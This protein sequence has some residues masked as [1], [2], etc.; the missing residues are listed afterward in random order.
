[1]GGNAVKRENL[2]KLNRLIGRI[3]SFEIVMDLKDRGW[4]A[5]CIEQ[6]EEIYDDEG[7][8]MAAIGFGPSSAEDRV[9]TAIRNAPNQELNAKACKEA[10]GNGTA[11]GKVRESLLA[12]GR[13]IER[14]GERGA[15]GRPYK[16]YRELL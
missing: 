5:D 15:A 8:E 11:W 6:L 12:R 2:T 4:F 1:M 9:L 10:A 3:E 7:G 16:F 14:V 13:I